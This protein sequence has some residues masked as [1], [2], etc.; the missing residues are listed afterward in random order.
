MRQRARQMDNEQRMVLDRAIS[1]FKDVAKARRTG[2]KMPSP[3]DVMVHGAAGTG[4]SNIIDQIC[5]FG[6]YILSQPG[7]NLDHPYIIKTAFMGTA[8][9]NIGGQ[10]LTSA[11]NLPFSTKHESLSDKVRDIKR[12]ELQNLTLVIID[13]ISMVK[14]DQLYQLDLRLQEI[15]DKRGTPYGGV[16]LFCFGDIFQLEPVMGR[17]VFAK[18]SNPA[19]HISH[20]LNSLWER[21]EVINLTTNHRQGADKTYGDMCNRFRKLVQ[22]EMLKEDNETL[23]QRVRPSDDSDIV[24]ADI[25]IV[26]KRATCEKINTEYLNKMPGDEVVIPSDN[27]KTNQKDFK[28]KLDPK[29]NTIGSTGFMFELKLKKGARVMLIKNIDTSDLLTNG[30]QGVLVDFKYIEGSTSIDFLV[31]RF[32]NPKVGKI[33]REKNPDIKYKY[34]ECTKIK[35]E[36]ETYTIGKNRSSSTA[37]LRQ[38][39]LK[40]A[41]AITAHKSQGQTFR[42][43]MTCSLHLREIFQANQGYVMCGR[44]QTINQVFIPDNFEADK[45]YTSQTIIDEDAKMTARSINMNPIPW[46]SDTKQLRLAHLNIANIKYHSLDLK[47]DPNFKKADLL[48]LSETWLKPDEEEDLG[49]LNIIPGHSL[50]LNSVGNGKGLA[51]FHNSD[52][53]PV[54]NIKEPDYQISVLSNQEVQSV[55]VYRSQSAKR[56]EVKDAIVALLNEDKVNIV[57]G[58]FNICTKKEPDNII[59]RCLLDLGFDLLLSGAT[60]IMGGTIDHTYVRDTRGIFETPVLHRYSPYYTD[61]DAHCITLVHRLEVSFCRLFSIILF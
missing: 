58:D 59:T 21:K 15:K 8:A 46:T 16:G 43:P 52:F 36:T 1:Y 17:A 18:P 38:F 19:F 37:T 28:P 41:K 30:Q 2:A 24:N 20:S 39:P 56:S 29:D 5:N 33:N 9:A 10:T 40:L 53:K 22:G 54:T 47:H 45:I 44:A 55:V 14:A 57:T 61:H 23:M 35:K 27:F 11:F 50:T 25:H 51:S 34:P 48:H 3:P 42:E 49:N 4:K 32:N 13:E 12:I 60:H 26:G 7:D 6:Q 31:V